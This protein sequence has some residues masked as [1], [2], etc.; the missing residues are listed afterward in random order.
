MSNEF[1]PYHK[2]LGIPLK[3]QPANHYRL[4][5]V[6]RFESDPDVITGASDQRVHFLRTLQTGD[7]GKMVDK[8]LNEIA[9]AKVCLL[10]KE[11]KAAY[12][13]KLRAQCDGD[14]P[15]AA[16]PLFET[17]AEPTA[18]R[19]GR[20]TRSSRRTT[21]EKAKDEKPTRPLVP[22]IAAVVVTL[23]LIGGG[24]AFFLSSQAEKRE[25]A[26]VAEI[27]KKEKAAEAERLAQ[28]EAEQKAKEKEDKRKAQEADRR[29]KEAEQ[30]AQIA[31]QKLKQV[32][33]RKAEEESKERAQAAAKQKAQAAAERARQQAAWEARQK[34]RR[35][36]EA[37]RKTE[38]ERKAKEKSQLKVKKSEDSA[39]N[40]ERADAIALLQ[41][42][43]L[44]RGAKGWRPKELSQ[45][46]TGMEKE[47]AQLRPDG[48]TPAQE[49]EVRELM[50][51]YYLEKFQLYNQLHAMG[52]NRGRAE[53]FGDDM[54]SLPR[55]E[56]ITHRYLSKN[57]LA[58]RRLKD[59]PNAPRKLA[60]NAVMER[61]AEDAVIKLL[62]Q[63]NPRYLMQANLQR[64]KKLK[65][66][67]TLETKS[68]MRIR[69]LQ[70][71]TKVQEAIET[72]GSKFDPRFAPK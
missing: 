16:A 8:L 4:L 45:L 13:Q 42:K 47:V 28:E 30:R 66:I 53:G 51:R 70:K 33:E 36:A 40:K 10:N 35:E 38:A 34:A 68:R 19:R 67:K 21:K 27:A 25:A 23:L 71:E 44:M 43:G 72:L 39:K 29:V 24:L 31:E 2:W 32:A 1:N 48:L 18:Q 9:N 20:S 26:R 3:D 12:D 37:K 41:A 46:L 69:S 55:E 15:S 57:L 5:G 14:V 63:K 49:K 65:Q 11:K 58:P 59:P 7:R 50:N 22:I 62:L 60:P 56:L 54:V 52:I 64:K 6:V 61:D 17:D